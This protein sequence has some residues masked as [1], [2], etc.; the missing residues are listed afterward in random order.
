MLI[1]V[2]VPVYNAVTYLEG[3]VNSLINQTY[4]NWELILVDDG[5]KDDSGQICD[6]FA[7]KDNRIHVIHQ[8]NT[9]AGAARNKGITVAKGD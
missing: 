3:N 1:S 4:N 9:G 5:S 8:K 7:Q 6:G 2:F